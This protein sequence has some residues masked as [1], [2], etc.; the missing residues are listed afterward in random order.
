MPWKLPA[1]LR[2]FRQ[3]TMGNPMIMG[4]ATFESIG[5]PLPGRTNIVLTRDRGWSHSGVATAHD[6]DSAM[7]IAA[8]ETP[9]EICVI[10]GAQIYSLFMDLADRLEI[11]AIDAAPRGDTYFPA[12]NK[13]H[14]RL[15][16]TAPQVGPPR[17]RFETCL[18]R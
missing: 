4:R 11:T 1:D 8:A 7:A 13:D 12:W 3:L 14:W 2:R 5:R 17:Y 15:A 16:T 18:R 10:G 9:N 6:A